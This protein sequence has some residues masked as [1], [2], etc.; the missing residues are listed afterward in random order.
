MFDVWSDVMHVGKR[1]AVRNDLLHRLCTIDLGF[2]RARVDFY[3]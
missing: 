2:Q 1:L 3:K